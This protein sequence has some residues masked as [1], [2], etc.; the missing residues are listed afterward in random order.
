MKAGLL[1]SLGLHVRLGDPQSHGNLTIF[2]LVGEDEGPPPYLFLQD[3]LKEGLVEVGEV[4]GAVVSE[5][6]ATNRGE[7][8]L[9][10]IMGEELLG[11]KQNRMVNVTVLV[12]AMASLRVPVSCTEKGRW[13][14][15]KWGMKMARTS[16]HY[17][18]CCLRQT[19]LGSVSDSINLRKTYRSDQ[20]EI[21]HAISRSLSS[22]RIDSETG[23]QS[24]LFT[25]KKADMEGYLGH[26]HSIPDQVGMVGV[27]KGELKGLDL[28]GSEDTMKKMFKKLLES[29]II[30]AI[31]DARES[32]GT[33]GAEV[34]DFLDD[35]QR[36]KV[37][38][39]PAPGK[40]EHLLLEGRKQRGMAL[41][42]DDR[43]LHLYSAPWTG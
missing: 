37:K 14:Q 1:N 28:F 39:M 25:G 30:E 3:A 5:L 26:F 22:L 31:P 6:V 11:A 34:E 40:G 20:V 12:P 15:E 41:V 19:L 33:M 24:E 38:R 36:A 17:T 8:D 9:L 32:C 29:Y 18:T 16:D 4:G 2:P 27:V 42:T 35:V 7:R 23:A 10:L 43:L 21:W 13:R